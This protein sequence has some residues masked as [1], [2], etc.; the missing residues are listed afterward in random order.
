[1]DANTMGL[2][3]PPRVRFAL[4]VALIVV[5]NSV[6][7][8]L[9]TGGPATG[10]LILPWL[11]TIVLIVL[12][13]AIIGQVP[14]IVDWRGVLVDQRNKMSLSRLQLVVWTILVISATITEGVLNAVWGQKTPLNLSIPSELWILLG[15]STGAF[16][17]A[18]LVLDNKA[19]QGT[20]H[21][22]P[23]NHHAWSDIFYG[24]DTGN[25]DQVD[26]SKVQ[27][28]FFTVVLTVVYAAGLGNVMATTTPGPQALLH[29]PPLD[30]G[31]IG[32]MAVSQL[33]YIAYKAV[34][35]N[36]TDAPPD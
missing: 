7:G 11:I 18:P 9:S 26:F 28:F 30:P 13:F 10:W 3:L 32:I 31:F 36:K 16:V 19:D 23:L 33:A 20:L 17:A 24:D 27:Q 14:P 8:V 1:M 29:F 12:C 34:P 2:S 35:Q 6:A 4:L 21:T 15:L 22:K 25:A 5:V